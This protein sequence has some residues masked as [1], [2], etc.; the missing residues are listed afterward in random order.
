MD[1]LDHCKDLLVRFGGHELAAGLTVMRCNIDEFRKRINDYAR[2]NLTEDLSCIR[3]MADCELNYDEVSMS[4]ANEISILEPFGVA[5]A[6]P[7]FM[8]RG[9]QLGK[10]ISMGAGKHTKLL[11]SRGEHNY[12]AVCFGMSAASLDIFP[13]EYVDLM[14]QISINEFRGQKSVQLVVQDVRLSE[15]VSAGYGSEMARYHQVLSGA[16]FSEEEDILPTRADIAEIYKLLR[17]ENMNGHT[18]FNYRAFK[19]YV[20]DHCRKNMSLAKIRFALNILDDIQVC[21]VD[22]KETDFFSVEVNRNAAKTNIEL[23]ETYRR[24]CEQCIG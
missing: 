7:V 22:G 24:L 18:L 21:R 4:L 16:R 6:A 3:Y 19:L 12:Q 13:G 5:N 15:D 8:I 1:A 14:C 10:I 11:L 2:E 9:L 20:A 23:S 17:R